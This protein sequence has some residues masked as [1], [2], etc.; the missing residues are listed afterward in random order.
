MPKR[1]FLAKMTAVSQSYDS[2]F[3]SSFFPQIGRGFVLWEP[4]LEV[5]KVILGLLEMCSEADWW[6]P[7][8]KYGLPLTAGGDA[9]RTSRHTLAQVRVSFF[10]KSSYSSYFWAAQQSWNRK[11]FGCDGRRRVCWSLFVFG[12]QDKTDKQVYSALSVYRPKGRWIR[13]PGLL[14]AIKC[15]WSTS[16]TS[17]QKN[18]VNQLRDS[19]TTRDCCWTPGASG[20]GS[21]L[22]TGFDIK[23]YLLRNRSLGLSGSVELFL[24]LTQLLARC[25]FS[26]RAVLMRMAQ[27]NSFT[28]LAV[29]WFVH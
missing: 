1:F 15:C 5:S 8:A 9:C 6:V 27:K 14:L 11:E 25:W 21:T 22:L 16:S 26:N 28:T 18:F 4:H 2:R 20:I 17:V 10:G 13:W 12:W 29:V 24:H 3:T 7:S 23:E 19:T